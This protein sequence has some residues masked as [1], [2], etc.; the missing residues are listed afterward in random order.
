M[1]YLLSILVIF[2]CILN[3][4]VVLKISGI[5]LNI[6]KF[7]P[8][9]FGFSYFIGILFLIVSVR[10]F[11]FFFSNAFIGLLFFASFSILIIFFIK[12]SNFENIKMIFISKSL[13]RY[14]SACGYKI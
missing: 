6:D 8:L 10:V 7:K 9:Y 5:T 13:I 4:L 1:D 12:L 3:G 2:I 11:S 14:Y